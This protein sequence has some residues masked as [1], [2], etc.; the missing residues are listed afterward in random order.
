[1]SGSDLKHDPSSRDA[2]DI[3]V[4]P[5]VLTINHSSTFMVMTERRDC[6]QQR[7]GRLRQRYPVRQLLRDLRER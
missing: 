4:G 1:M 2:I 6:R 5:P 7:T 3:S